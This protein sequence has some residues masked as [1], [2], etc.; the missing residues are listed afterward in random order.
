M[1]LFSFLVLC[2]ATIQL[3]D[4]FGGCSLGIVFYCGTLTVASLY[5]SVHWVYFDRF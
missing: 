1:M 3:N 4:P 2:Y 5:D